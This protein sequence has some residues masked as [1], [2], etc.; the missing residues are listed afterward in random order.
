MKSRSFMGRMSL[1]SVALFSI[2][3][4]SCDLTSDIPDVPSIPPM[5]NPI[6]HRQVVSLI[7]QDPDG[8]NIMEPGNGFIQA[9]KPVKIS[10]VGKSTSTDTPNK[11]LYKM[12]LLL[13]ESRSRFTEFTELKEDEIPAVWGRDPK[14]ISAI[15]G[16]ALSSDGS[17]MFYL[18]MGFFKGVDTEHVCTIEWPNGEKDKITFTIK[19][20]PE[21]PLA[22]VNAEAD[23]W[24]GYPDSYL[25]D[26]VYEYADG[27][28]QV[29]LSSDPA[30]DPKPNNVIVKDFKPFM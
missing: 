4:S 5:P 22:G 26:A 13:D 21:K 17:G 20:N 12:G 8:R 29:I 11:E 3:L 23:Y 18:V 19:E 2:A 25:T 28:K 16:R 10:V 7:I 30:A 15:A 6:G 1:L 27:T 9:N 14:G 24:L